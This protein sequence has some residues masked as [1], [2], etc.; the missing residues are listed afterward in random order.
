MSSTKNGWIIIAFYGNKIV[1][2][3]N[4]VSHFSLHD[5]EAMDV[6]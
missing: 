2:E 5:L 6:L 4:Q 1:K 3:K